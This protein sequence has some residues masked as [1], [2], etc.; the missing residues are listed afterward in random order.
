MRKLLY[1][2]KNFCVEE[3]LKW[4]VENVRGEVILVCG[5]LFVASDARFALHKLKYVEFP[6]NDWAHYHEFFM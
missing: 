5:S 2:D 4:V 1:K 3:G 6:E